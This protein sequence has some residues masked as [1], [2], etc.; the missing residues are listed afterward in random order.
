MII[1][2]CEVLVDILIVNVAVSKIYIDDDSD[3]LLV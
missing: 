1:V 2:R 3:D